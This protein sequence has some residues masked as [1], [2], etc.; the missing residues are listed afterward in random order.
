MWSSQFQ[1]F[2]I[3]YL[4]NI[5][6]MPTHILSKR[7]L[8]VDAGVR[9]YTGI[10]SIVREFINQHQH[11]SLICECVLVIIFLGAIM[12]WFFH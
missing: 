5:H 11:M 7:M 4:A 10:G 6:M 12:A 9:D 3:Q 2:G 8:S 1:Y